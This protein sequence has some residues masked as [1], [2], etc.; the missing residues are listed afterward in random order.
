MIEAWLFVISCVGFVIG[1]ACLLAV[2]KQGCNE[3]NDARRRNQAY[4]VR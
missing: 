3:R 4:R 2:A 1:V